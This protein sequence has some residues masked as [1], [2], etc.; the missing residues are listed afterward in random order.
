[1]ACAEAKHRIA[2]VIRIFFMRYL[3]RLKSGNARL[4]HD[5]S[6]IFH[7]SLRAT[8]YGAENSLYSRPILKFFFLLVLNVVVLRK[9]NRCFL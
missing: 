3:F 1:M 6:N 8:V 5:C 4:S 7:G 2:E 9:Q